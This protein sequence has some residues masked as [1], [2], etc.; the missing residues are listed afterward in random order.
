MTYTD[1]I[2]GL[3]ETKDLFNVEQAFAL[4]TTLLEN[5]DISKVDFKLIK[6]VTESTLGDIEESLISEEERMNLNLQFSF[7]DPNHQV[8][9]YVPAWVMLNLT[10]KDLEVSVLKRRG[11]RY[12]VYGLGYSS[13]KKSSLSSKDVRT[14]E[15]N[16]GWKKATRTISHDRNLSKKADAAVEDIIQDLEK[17]LSKDIQIIGKKLLEDYI[18]SHT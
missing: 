15:K 8:D 11:M 18:R 1:K 17:A 3:I 6:S 2:L 14:I 12:E 9:I 5:G 16:R 4:A 7:N 10:L 13:P